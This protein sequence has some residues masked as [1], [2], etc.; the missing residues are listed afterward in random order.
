[1]G[2]KKKVFAELASVAK[3]GAVLA[4]NTSYLNI[5]EIAGATARAQDVIG[6]HFFSP[7]NVMRLLEI[8]RTKEGSLEA[9]ATANAVALKMKKI[10]VF[11]GVCDGF[12]GNRIFKRYRQQ[13]EYLVEDGA[14]PADVD[15][16]MREFGF[17]MGPF[18]V[19]DLAGLDIGW[20]NRRRE[21]ATRDPA[22]RYVDV[23]DHLYDLGRLGQ[24]TGA[25]WY[26]YEEGDRTPLTDPV[27]EELS[28]CAGAS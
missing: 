8:I 1:M 14:I 6:M 24:K 28:R 11:A 17:A 4:S 16:V 21:D 9:L 15:R 7:A 18:E 3:P 23:A 19:S 5:N 2:V 22:E 25:G 10:P 27:V 13:A 12:I 20:A 26:R